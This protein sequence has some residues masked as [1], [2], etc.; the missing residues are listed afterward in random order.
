MEKKHIISLAGELA[1]GKST[2]A[3]LLIEDLKYGLYKN[4]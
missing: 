2:V 1:S 4:G 3:K